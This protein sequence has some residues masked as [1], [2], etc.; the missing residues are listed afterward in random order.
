MEAWR[1]KFNIDDFRR[2]G[3]INDGT[4]CTIYLATHRAGQEV[5][6]N[7]DS[8]AFKT[9]LK[10]AEKMLLENGVSEQT[11]GAILA[12]AKELSNDKMFWKDQKDGLVVF[13]S[14]DVFEYYQLPFH[15]ETFTYVNKSYYLTP[16]IPA[17]TDHSD[18]YLLSLSKNG[19][20]FF[21]GTQYEMVPIDVSGLVPAGLSDAMKYEVYEKQKQFRTGGTTG[22]GA[23]FFSNDRKDYHKKEELRQYLQ[24][25]NDG[26]MKIIGNSADPLVLAGVEYVTSCYK[27]ISKYSNIQ[28]Q[29]IDGN[30]EHATDSDLHERAW[31]IVKPYFDQQRINAEHVYEDLSATDKTSSDVDEI[32]S[33]S[34][35]SRVEKLFLQENCHIWGYFDERNN[36]VV[37]H[38]SYK[39][40][41]EDLANKA[42]VS[43]LLNGG[44]VYLTSNLRMP[45]QSQNIAAVFRYKA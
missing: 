31:A 4:C 41:D 36:Q 26:I 25:V 6:E 19:V 39:A 1:N 21:Y 9:E 40:G 5:N 2:L 20:S 27:A 11:C 14:E 13:L 37:L 10:K 43:T 32:I 33:G 3:T 15:V 16:L 44:E 42:A 17:V 45:E 29:T 23:L 35:F 12:R 38:K 7:L 22:T 8:K 30:Q 24:M 18:F 28:E 34:V